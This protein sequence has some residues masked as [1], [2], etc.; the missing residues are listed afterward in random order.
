MSLTVIACDES[1]SEGENLIASQ[2]PV[3]VHGSTSLPQADLRAIHVVDSRDD[4]RVQVADILAGTGREVAR[5]AAEGT[6][7]DPLQKVV[8]PMLDRSVMS[9][10]GSPVDRL[11][12]R[13]P[14][15]YWDQWEARLSADDEPS[16]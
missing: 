4:A 14:L 10:G 9:S 7:D 13:A 1:A 12:E 5:L 15:R 2:H 16:N 8:H 6:F 3:F 11:V